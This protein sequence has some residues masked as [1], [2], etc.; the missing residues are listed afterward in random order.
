MLLFDPDNGPL[1]LEGQLVGMTLWGSGLILK[2]RQAVFFIA[3]V[4]FVAGLAGD[5]EIP[6]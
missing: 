2:P 1:H 5:A 6:A 4:D 3:I